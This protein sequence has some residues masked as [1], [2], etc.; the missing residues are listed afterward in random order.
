MQHG[1]ADCT[2]EACIRNLER[3]RVLFKDL[4]VGTGQS[5][6][7]RSRKRRIDLNC[8]QLLRPEAQQIGG[9]ARPGADL[10]HLIPKLRPLED[11]REDVA[12]QRSLP[13]SGATQNAM[14]SIHPRTSVPVFFVRQ[15]G[16]CIRIHATP[17]R[18]DAAGCHVVSPSPAQRSPSR[19]RTERCGLLQISRSLP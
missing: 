1:Q 17:C 12:L 18:R 11:P 10:D 9:Q 19:R 4:H 13:D 16:A 15:P 14:A 2:I 6:L 7:Q 8:G 5:L 3:G